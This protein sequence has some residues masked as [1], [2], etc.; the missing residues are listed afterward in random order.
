M[1]D[2]INRITTLNEDVSK[3]LIDSAFKA[4]QRNSQLVQ[5]WVETINANSQAT[6][7]LA[8]K[9][10]EQTKQAQTLWVKFAQDLLKSNAEAINEVSKNGFQNVNET[11]DTVGRQVKNTTAAAK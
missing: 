9:L 11:L 5:N 10:A 2:T 1:N 4:Q 8:L 3:E 6:R 7:D